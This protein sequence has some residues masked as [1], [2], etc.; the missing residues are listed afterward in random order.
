VVG[1]AAIAISKTANNG[2]KA[3]TYDEIKSEVG[4]RVPDSIQLDNSAKK[5]LLRIARETLTACVHQKDYSRIISSLPSLNKPLGAFVTLHKYGNLRG[6]IGRFEPDFPVKEIV[7]DMTIAAALEDP[8]FSPVTPDELKDIQIEISVLTPRRLI[9]D[10][11]EIQIGKHGLYLKKGWY[12][13]TLLPQVATEYKWDV[14]TFLQHT[15]IKAGLPANAWE[16]NDTEIYIYSAI[17]FHEE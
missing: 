8:R 14:E 16:E 13:G 7:R 10:I 12:S 5:E 6:C 11:K 17:I 4:M 9:N 15:C 1:Y 3:P 2:L